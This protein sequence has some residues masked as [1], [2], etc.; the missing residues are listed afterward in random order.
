[1]SSLDQSSHQ[2]ATDSWEMMV[3]F[4]LKRVNVLKDTRVGRIEYSMSI[5][6]M[7]NALRYT[8]YI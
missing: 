1:M 4:H 8:V 2:L 6:N 7:F 5:Y 3:E